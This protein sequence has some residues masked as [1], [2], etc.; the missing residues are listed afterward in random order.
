MWY[1]RLTGACR[2][3]TIT[4]TSN[5]MMLVLRATTGFCSWKESLLARLSDLS[6]L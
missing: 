1:G 6:V 2:L 3:T 4:I 5:M